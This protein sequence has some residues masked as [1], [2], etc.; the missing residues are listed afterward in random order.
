MAHVSLEND[1]TATNYFCR[2]TSYF[3]RELRGFKQL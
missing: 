2:E 3:C 1:T